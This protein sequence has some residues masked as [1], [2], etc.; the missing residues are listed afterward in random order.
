MRAEQSFAAASP[1][2]WQGV[3]PEFDRVVTEDIR[4]RLS[5][6]TTMGGAT[7]TM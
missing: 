7:M 1:E 5:D 3:S 4:D 2:E 6:F